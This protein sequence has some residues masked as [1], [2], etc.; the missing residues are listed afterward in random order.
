MEIDS[1]YDHFDGTYVL[2][3]VPG[4]CRYVY[5]TDDWDFADSLSGECDIDGEFHEFDPPA[6]RVRMYCGSSGCTAFRVW[7]ESIDYAFCLCDPYYGCY[8]NVGNS[9]NVGCVPESRW[10]TWTGIYN[11]AHPEPWS[12]C[13]DMRV[14]PL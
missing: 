3:Y 11:E 7:I 2:D 9:W 12:D 13:G 1:C 6:M 14:T 10:G 5:Q 4:T 8:W